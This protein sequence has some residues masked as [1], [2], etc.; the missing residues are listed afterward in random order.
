[1]KFKRYIVS[2]LLFAASL[3]VQPILAVEY[4]A[5]EEVANIA[6]ESSVI[7]TMQLAPT[8]VYQAVSAEDQLNNY[9][10]KMGLVEGANEIKGRD[11]FVQM[12]L[13]SFD[14]KDPASDASFMIKRSMKAMEAKL[15]A[16]AKIIEAI[17]T[18]MSASEMVDVPGTDLNAQFDA[19]RAEN[20]AQLE[21][22]KQVL[23][24][25]LDDVDRKQA[26]ELRGVTFSDRSAALMDAVIKKLDENYSSSDLNAERKAA[27]Q[28][29]KLKFESA[30]TEYLK[31]E[32][33]IN[34]L[35]KV[36][37][38]TTSKTAT[39]SKMPLFG[40]ITVNQ[41]ESWNE[42][43]GY[44]IALLVMWSKST[45]KM[46]RS[47]MSL[48]GG[49]TKKT[50]GRM[51]VKNWVKSQNWATITGG[52]RFKDDKGNGWF[53]GVDARA[54]GKTS[55]SKSKARGVAEMGAKKEVAMALFADMESSKISETMMVENTD[56]S[57]EA[58]DSMTKK[59][60]ANIRN[61]SIS[62]LQKIYGR[63]VVHPISGQKIYVAVYGI[64]SNTARK[65]LSMQKSNYATKL[66]DVKHQQQLKGTKAGLNSAVSAAERDH[67]AY[68]EAKRD[69]RQQVQ[70]QAAKQSTTAVQPAVQQRKANAQSNQG[71]QAGVYGGGG[72]DSFDW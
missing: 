56:G 67:T 26:D 65:A 45:E 43:D 34:T 5:S 24:I 20:Q 50:P 62:G 60:Q 55:V 16:K 51:S 44:E 17:H 21:E 4:T 11:V 69:A 28:D 49:D 66:L 70:Q 47:M 31:I 29:A 53:I 12:G 48:E 32:K 58:F 30:Q 6:A 37:Q 54:L 25:L 41:F 71:S 8:P 36:A 59:I 13:A 27:Y 42:E 38:I 35:A 40:A 3:Q 46:V 14:T 19:R 15:D 61:R 52:R 2:S 18:T 1:M 64:S 63:K 39:L 10:D 33:E 7:E 22:Q 9:L 23:A 57:S 68:Q 72:A